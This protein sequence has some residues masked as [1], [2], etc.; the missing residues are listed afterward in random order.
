MDEAYY[1]HGPYLA[2]RL[3]RLSTIIARDGFPEAASLVA[4]AALSVCDPASGSEPP[5][6]C[7]CS[8][9]RRRPVKIAVD[10]VLARQP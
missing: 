3:Y 2:R 5:A 6:G 7:H 8:A 9:A 10:P 1:C 4:I